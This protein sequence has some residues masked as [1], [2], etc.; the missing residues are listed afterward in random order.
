MAPSVAKK[1][2][3]RS[4]SE[5]SKGYKKKAAEPEEDIQEEVSSSEDE[6]DDK[7]SED[8]SE[9]DELD[10][11]DSESE[12]ELDD[13]DEDDDEEGGS[14]KEGGDQK[15]QKTDGDENSKTSKEQH[16]EQKKLLKERKLKRNAGVEIAQIKAIWEKLRV[17]TPPIPKKIRDK[18]C[19]EIWTLSKSCIKDLVLKHDASR[20]VQTLVKYSDKTVRHEVVLELKD[21]YFDLARSSYGKYLLIKLLHYGTK[22]SREIIIDEL[23]GK[24]RKLLRHREG[25]YVVEDLFVLYSTSKQRQQMIREFW[26]ARYALFKDSVKDGQT[27]L[28]VVKDN[29]ESRSLIASNLNQTITAAV[30]KGSTGFQLLH[31]VMKE[32]IQ[33]ASDKDMNEFVELLADQVAELVHTP[34]GCE[35]ACVVIAKASAKQ[36]KAIIKS[37]KPHAK[38]M[39]TNEHGNLVLLTLFL[40]VDDTKL[41]HKSFG[42]AEFDAEQMAELSVDKF[43]RRPFLYLLCGLDGKY[44]NPHVMKSLNRYT[45]MSSATSKKPQESRKSELL[46]KFAPLFY[47]AIAKYNGKVFSENI[48][49][50]FVNE[51]MIHAPKEES[52]EESRTQAINSII[53]ALQGEISQDDHLI[54]K[55][56]ASR[57]LKSLIQ[58]GQWNFK[59]QVIEK[60]NDSQI[61]VPFAHLLINEV[62]K[63]ED[64]SKWIESKNGSF[65]VAGLYEALKKEDDKESKEFVKSV[66][67]F[68]KILKKLGDENKGGKLLLK[69]I[70]A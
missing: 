39:I 34:D 22:E 41:V 44:F 53:S 6:L 18:L 36:R 25:A 17:K 37:L 31:A 65:I 15:R 58:G 13:K 30:E 51:V 33:V 42:S 23:H 43:A 49:L 2:I 9:E 55:P 4:S 62:V 40:T 67:K 28:D 68:K 3:K 10:D 63:S 27:I 61:G 19:S 26:G 5:I 16:A 54:N 47:E 21:H 46:S 1:G 20:V 24:L 59:Q 70:E 11:A 50:Q 14:E 8:E 7:M 35:V 56:F 52:L 66:G 12:D 32:Y 45:E 29:E 48:G 60:D 57:L 69:L 38:A 64:L